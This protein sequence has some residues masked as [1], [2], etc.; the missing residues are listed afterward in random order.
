MADAKEEFKKIRDAYK[1]I[2]EAKTFTALLMGT[3]STGKTTLIGT[4]RKPIL[5][6]S[7]D[8]A[9][10]VVLRKQIESG[11]VLVRDWSVD[12]YKNPTAYNRW[13][14]QWELDIKNKFLMNFGTYAIDSVTTFITALSY[15]ISKK[16]GRPPSTLAIQDYNL[17]YAA[18]GD[19]ISLSSVQG[20]DFIMTAHLTLTKDELSGEVLA[21]I[22]TYNRLKT[23]LPNLF[24]ERY[25]LRK[26]EKSSGIEYEVLTND[27][28]RYRAGSKLASEGKIE[29]IEKPDLKA[30]MKKAGYPLTDKPLFLEEGGAV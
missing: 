7:F 30:I 21:E 11:E 9:G 19:V 27:Q 8:P 10:A 16:A 29:R 5:I 14:A 6:D 24:S 22:D 4:G 12:N 18:L 20:C 17:I 2:G 28:G 25:V 23:K 3:F 15:A 26:V 13:E 1:N